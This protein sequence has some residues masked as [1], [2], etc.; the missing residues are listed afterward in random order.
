[1]GGLYNDFNACLLITTVS[2]LELFGYAERLN[3]RLESAYRLKSNHGI[4]YH[5]IAAPAAD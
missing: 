3:R 2:Y 4:P 5:A 1:M